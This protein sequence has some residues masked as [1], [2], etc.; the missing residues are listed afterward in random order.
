MNFFWIS[1][2]SDPEQKKKF[3]KWFN[4]I[5]LVT[6]V[7]IISDAF[8][9]FVSCSK[10]I[11]KENNNKTEGQR[12]A[13]KLCG[14]TQ[15]QI[16]LKIELKVN[17]WTCEEASEKLFAEAERNIQNWHIQYV[18]GGWRRWCESGTLCWGSALML[19]MP[20]NVHFTHFHVASR[21]RRKRQQ[22][23]EINLIFV[24]IYL[25]TLCRLLNDL[26]QPFSNVENISNIFSLKGSIILRWSIWTNVC[27]PVWKFA[28]C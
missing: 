16:T 28:L 23:K 7:N 18:K 6:N 26:L 20:I 17:N 19:K 25:E 13:L 2:R 21:R 11:E 1:I 24:Y 12:T 27:Q 14:L 9:S 5:Y 8:R 10:R 3:F 4:W 22:I 15:C